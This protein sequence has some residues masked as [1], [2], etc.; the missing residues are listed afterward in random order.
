MISTGNDGFDADRENVF[1]RALLEILDEG[2]I[3][4]R[5][6]RIEN[7]YNAFTNNVTP[8]KSCDCDS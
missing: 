2:D 5:I 6:Y 3:V 7:Q 4:D 1:A 8:I